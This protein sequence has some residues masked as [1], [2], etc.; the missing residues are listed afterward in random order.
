MNRIDEAKAKY[1]QY[2]E[3][4]KDFQA[5]QAHIDIDTDSDEGTRVHMEIEYKGTQYSL[6]SIQEKDINDLYKY[7]NSQALVRAKFGNGNTTSLETTT[8]RANTFISRFRNKDSPLYL[9]SGFIVSDSQ[10]ES[11]LGMVNL[12]SGVE[13]GTAEMARLN[14]VECW[15]SPPS[16]GTGESGIDSK[17]YSGIGTAETCALLQYAAQL[18][19]KGHHVR[20]H[21]LRAVVASARVDNEG[22]WKS[23]AKAGMILDSVAA[24]SSYGSDLRYYLRKEL[25]YTCT[26]IF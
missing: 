16:T 21:P 7:I 12:G 25:W 20:G 13:N 1:Y 8:A 19:E 17:V 15:S 26:L 11:F 18:K 6:Q 4:Q 24:Q 9:Y 3:G 14:R 23:N 22:S 5:P 10:T 2:F